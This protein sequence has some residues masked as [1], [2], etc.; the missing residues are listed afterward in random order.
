[1]RLLLCTALAL[2]AGIAP[3]ARS[4]TS[5]DPNANVRPI[6]IVSAEA[7]EP[8]RLER[9]DLRTEV[10]G[11]HAHTRVELTLRN[12]NDRV[13]EGELQFPL[14]DG[15]TLT[16]FAL[17]IDGEWRP[18]VPIDKARGQQVFEDVTRARVDPALLESTQGNNYKLRVYPLPARGTRRVALQLAQTLTAAP[19]D[20]S[21]MR[22]HQPLGF[23]ASAGQLSLELQVASVAPALLRSSMRGLSARSL[24]SVPAGDGTTLRVGERNVGNDAAFT[25]TLPRRAQSVVAT[26]AVG[27]RVYFDADLALPD[28]GAPRTAPRRITL[29]WDASGSGAGRDRAREFGV[30]DAYLKA[31]HDVDVDLI[32]GRD[33]VEPARRFR[34][35]G[36]RWTALREALAETAHDGAS[37]LGALTAAADGDLALLFSDGLANWGPLEMPRARVPLYALSASASVDV[38][39][40]RALA[41]PAGGRWIDLLQTSAGAA[42]RELQWSRTRLVGLS[43]ADDAVAESRFAVDGRLRVAGWTSEPRTTLRLDFERPD[44]RSASES[45]VI[46]AR[47]ASN[48]AGQ[49]AVR[50]PAVDDARAAW[51]AQ[52]WAQLRI[53][54][55]DAAPDLHRA[56]IR[57][58]GRAHGLVTRETSLIVLDSAA[59]YARHEIDP[60]AALRAEVERLLATQRKQ[61][62]LSRTVHLN[63]VAERFARRVAWWQASYPKDA[64][65]IENKTVARERQSAGSSENDR[66]ATGQLRRA[67]VAAPMFAPA[68]PT[69]SPALAGATAPRQVADAAQRKSA[70]AD[71]LAAAPTAVRL[72][73]WASDSPVA[74]RL[75]DAPPE[76]VYR[77]YLDERPD[78]ANSTA[79]FLDAA[80]TLAAKG[81][82]ELALRVLS[83]L[84]E[85]N[86]ENRH[87]LRV[88]GYRLLQA[89]QPELAI[90]VLRE[91][92]RLSPDEPQS[93]RDLGLAL[94]DAG[95]WKEAA[96]RLWDVVARP[97]NARFPDIDQ[98]ALAELNALVERAARA[99]TPVQTTAFDTRLLRNLPVDLRITLAWDADNTDIDLWVIDPNGERAYYG[100]P[101]TRQ[102]GRMS[103]DATGGYGPEEFVLRDAK[104][105]RY[106]VQAQ[107]YGHRQQVLLSATTVMLRLT[108]GFGRPDQKDELTS[109]RL[110]DRSDLVMVGTFEVG[111]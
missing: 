100:H 87:M 97:W 36:G 75:R 33:R 78:H 22:F 9:V 13:L 71:D 105:G 25:L 93:H 73:P 95:Q 15:Q 109:L 6:R 58:L 67:E 24:E 54:E 27:S 81:S 85:M 29:L 99:G 21:A 11:R 79:F 52:R 48:A 107:Y 72:T 110:N 70:S 16:G 49:S 106:T 42:S 101:Q 94:A 108:T 20:A 32:V 4:Q 10:V 55:L 69:P 83:N 46:D 44:G 88:L 60:P 3:G 23:A 17:D 84:A 103:Q 64:P 19:G 98:I 65:P 41:E 12:P 28:H 90:R 102:G 51:V 104:P 92:L 38:P 63:R 59:D 86:L 45:V 26:Q 7:R 50:V 74:R 77:V 30:L 80:D 76:R 5:F 56:E 1:M 89:G 66:G 53:A 18:A 111:R 62:E 31:L 57:R 2:L 68:A 40:L 82:P 35:A 43:G 39:R 34:V 61:L 14:A 91:V 37:N 8:I 47:G 96:E